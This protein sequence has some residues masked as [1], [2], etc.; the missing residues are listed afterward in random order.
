MPP[1]QPDE[2]RPLR[3]AAAGLLYPSESDEPIEVFSWPGKSASTAKDAVVA[4][5]RRPE[6]LEERAVDQFFAAMDG[7]DDAEKFR[8][9]RKALEA[10]VR[11]VH[12]FRAGEVQVE[13]FVIGRTRGGDWAGLRTVAVE[14]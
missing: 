8:A 4:H 7:G 6:P 3:Q 14:T 13:V 10:V 1:V 9:V 2:L 11:D 12:V 5:A